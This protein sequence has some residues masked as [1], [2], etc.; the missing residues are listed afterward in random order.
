MQ[1]RML[2]SPVVLPITGPV[3]VSGV[4]KRTVRV[5]AKEETSSGQ[6]S[7][8]V[9]LWTFELADIPLLTY[10]SAGSGVLD[11]STATQLQDEL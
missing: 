6:D 4:S 3:R 5:A 1:T 9:R 11:Q 2:S 10:S 7:Y 8:S